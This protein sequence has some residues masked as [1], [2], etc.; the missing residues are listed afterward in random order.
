MCRIMPMFWSR[1]SKI[2]GYVK[3][4]RYR[5]ILLQFPRIAAR[6]RAIFAT[7]TPLRMCSLLVYE[8]GESRCAHA[9][10]WPDGPPPP[11]SHV[12]SPSP[13][14]PP[15]AMARCIGAAGR[16]VAMLALHQRP[17][18]PWTCCCCCWLTK[19]E[20]LPT[21]SSY[22]QRGSS[23]LLPLLPLPLSSHC[24]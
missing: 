1:S 18:Q 6:P 17:H 9:M 11:L 19:L 21:R 7:E 20:R 24:I 23:P 13:P 5:R 3:H 10:R 8:C 16:S 2:R 22:E 12:C 4:I 15:V 14:S